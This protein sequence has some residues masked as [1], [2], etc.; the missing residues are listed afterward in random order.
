LEKPA[1][2]HDKLSQDSARNESRSDKL[3]SP[4]IAGLNQPRGAKVRYIPI[5]K[6]SPVTGIPVAARSISTPCHWPPG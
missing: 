5:G 1:K 6:T 3:T 2:P 4:S